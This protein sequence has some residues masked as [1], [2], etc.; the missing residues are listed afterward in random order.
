MRLHM[1][2]MDMLLSKYWGF[3]TKHNKDDI[4]NYNYSFT[5][6]CLISIIFCSKFSLKLD[7]FFMRVL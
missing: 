3:T 4:F 2:L 7:L 1:A 5:S 6:N